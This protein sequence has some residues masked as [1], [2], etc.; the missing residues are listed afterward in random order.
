MEPAF[1]FIKP[2]NT[3][4]KFTGASEN[5]DDEHG[6]GLLLATV[7]HISMFPDGKVLAFSS[8]TLVIGEL[9]FYTW[10][11]ME[12]LNMNHVTYYQT[13]ADRITRWV[14]NREIA[15]E[16]HSDPGA[17]IINTPLLDGSYLCDVTILPAKAP[18]RARVQG[19][20]VAR[21]TRTR[22]SS[23]HENSFCC[24][25]LSRRQA[26]V[27]CR[28]AR[29][30]CAGALPVSAAFLFRSAAPSVSPEVCA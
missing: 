21:I 9:Y 30:V 10:P 12:W 19:A 24:L 29:F 1:Y 3:I 17:R 5:P 2:D 28:G 14:N 25:L 22:H 16:G 11:E 23:A 6:L 20:A 26:T 4:V 18:L 15:L 7:D 13:D 27:V 8:S